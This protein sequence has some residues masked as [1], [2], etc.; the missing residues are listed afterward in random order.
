[1]R[2]PFSIF[3]SKD[4]RKAKRNVLKPAPT[5]FQPRVEVLEERVLLT[6]LRLPAD[7]YDSQVIISTEDIQLDHDEQPELP[8]WFSGF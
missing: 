4:G 7:W 6:C 8:E 1:M 2:F 3:G 5:G